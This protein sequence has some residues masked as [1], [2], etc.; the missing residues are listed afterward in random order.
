MLRGRCVIAPTHG[1]LR[2]IGQSERGWG[3]Y[4]ATPLY[5]RLKPL[6]SMKASSLAAV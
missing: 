5:L 3:V 6:D 4:A 1:V 2:M